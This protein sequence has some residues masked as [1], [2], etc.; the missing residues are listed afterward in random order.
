MVVFS[1]DA[2]RYGIDID[3]V[4]KVVL[5][6][7]IT[8]LPKAPDIVLGVVNVHGEIVPVIDL[9]ARLRRPQRSPALTDHLVIART[10]KRRVALL[11]D[12]V[13]GVAEYSPQQLVEAQAIVPGTEYLAGVAKLADGMVLIH[14]LD[15][16][17]SLEEEQRLDEAMSDG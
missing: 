15:R 9:R 13:E 2:S 3:S 16:F 1:I 7:E 8:S 11:A 5:V 10:A 12:A 4:D 14:D 17:L 6:V